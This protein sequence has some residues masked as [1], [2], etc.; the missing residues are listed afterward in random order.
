MSVSK[1]VFTGF[2]YPEIFSQCPL[3]LER[4][5][6][7]YGAPGTGKT[8]LANAAVGESGLN[9]ITVKVNQASKL[10]RKLHSKVTGC[11]KKAHNSKAKRVMPTAMCLQSTQLEGRQVAAFFKQI[12]L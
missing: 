4:G 6:L 10:E 7:L 12:H 9:L 3:K 1:I 5:V 8:L 2:K 11:C